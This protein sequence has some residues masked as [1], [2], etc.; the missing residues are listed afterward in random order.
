MIQ[1]HQNEIIM[2]VSDALMSGYSNTIINTAQSEIHGMGSHSVT[3][4]IGNQQCWDN[5]L[6]WGSYNSLSEPVA[7]GD[8]DSL[9]ILEIV[10][11][12]YNANNRSN[13]RVLTRAGNEYLA[14]N[15]YAG[16][17]LNGTNVNATTDVTASKNMKANGRYITPYSTTATTNCINPT[18]SGGSAAATIGN[19]QFSVVGNLAILNCTI[20][21]N[22]SIHSSA[23]TL[24]QLYTAFKPIAQVGCIA[25]T[26]NGNGGSFGYGR[27]IIN[28]DGYI[29][30]YPVTNSAYS[31]CHRVYVNVNYVLS[32]A[33]TVS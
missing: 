8:L 5:S 12:G 18:Q 29:R 27:L 31:S 3:F 7:G 23:I 1:L 24:G 25:L 4:G 33:Y 16:G 6:I 2:N 30:I 26:D 9:S 11:N 32:T 21:W 17:N 13:A 22:E 28:T 20:A 19:L 15:L 10:G 14:G